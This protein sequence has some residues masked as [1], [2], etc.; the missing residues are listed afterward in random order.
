MIEFED[1]RSLGGGIIADLWTTVWKFSA[2][3][4]S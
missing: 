2:R 3:E 4:D 1:A